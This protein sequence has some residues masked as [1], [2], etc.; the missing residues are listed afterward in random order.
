MGKLELKYN[1]KI[2]FEKNIKTGRESHIRETEYV[3]KIAE[4]EVCREEPRRHGART[5]LKCA[6]DYRK[7]GLESKRLEKR[8]SEAKGALSVSEKQNG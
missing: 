3:E 1:G 5:C 6:S 2:R 7:A 8:I 4:C